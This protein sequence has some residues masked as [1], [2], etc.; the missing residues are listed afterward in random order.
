[1]PIAWYP[2]RWWDWC[3]SEYEKEQ[4]KLWGSCDRIQKLF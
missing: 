2:P 1:M 4:E 3:L